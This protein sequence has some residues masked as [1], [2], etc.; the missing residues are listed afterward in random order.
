MFKEK[1]KENKTVT[2]DAVNPDYY[3]DTKIAPIDV[4]EDWGL[5]FHLGSV[6][7]YIKRAG[8]KPGNSEI[9]DL[10]K[11]RWY[12]DRQISRLEGK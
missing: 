11:I 10:K 6:L 9:Q 1:D 12:L 2:K 4:I 7:K 3:N 8:K 5:G